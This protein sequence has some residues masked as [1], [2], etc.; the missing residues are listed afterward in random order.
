[1]KLNHIIPDSVVNGPGKRFTIWFQGCSIRCK[2]CINKDTWNPEAGREVTPENLAKEILDLKDEIDGITLTGGEPLDQLEGLLEFL[3]LV[4]KDLSV[5]LISGR[6][7]GVLDQEKFRKALGFV[8]ILCSGP[9]RAEFASRELLWMGSSN[10]KLETLT[11]RGQKQV[12]E[13]LK[14]NRHVKTELIID[15]KTGIMI[16]SGFSFPEYLTP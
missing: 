4:H 15:R 7:R 11:D 5:F 10:Q 8:D 9:F 6:E 14:S 13:Y 2:D 1:M 16:A 3:P 12:I